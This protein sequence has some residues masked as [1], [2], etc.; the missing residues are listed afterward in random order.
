MSTEMIPYV[1]TAILLLGFI[2]M[3]ISNLVRSPKEMMLDH[4]SRLRNLERGDVPLLSER[5]ERHEESIENLTHALTELSGKIEKLSIR[6]DGMA[7]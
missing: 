6:V 4:E 1:N 3:V 7:R 2:A 5:H